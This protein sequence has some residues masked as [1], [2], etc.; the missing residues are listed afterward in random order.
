MKEG[1]LVR[2]C[3]RIYCFRFLKE[4]LSKVYVQIM[5]ILDYLETQFIGF[6]KYICFISISLPISLLSV[7]LRE[8]GQG[9][10]NNF[11]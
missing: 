6:K 9:E 4:T 3:F 2:D 11:N 7:P 10:N 5:P 1:I 8:M